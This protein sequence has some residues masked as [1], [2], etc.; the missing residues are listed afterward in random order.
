MRLQHWFVGRALELELLWQGQANLAQ[1]LVFSLMCMVILSD[2]DDDGDQ[3]CNSA[4]QQLGNCNHANSP[5]CPE[6][7]EDAPYVSR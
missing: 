3:D 6:Y 4:E 2:D 1:I 7:I 5:K